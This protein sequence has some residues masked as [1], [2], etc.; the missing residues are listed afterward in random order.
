MAGQY[1]ES[2]SY[3][4]RSAGGG[5]LPARSGSP[6]LARW[7][8]L[9]GASYLA[10]VVAVVGASAA[11]LSVRPRLDSL[12]VALV[13]LL[14]SFV[15]ALLYGSRPAALAAILSFVAYNVL[16]LEPYYS[17]R[18]ARPHDL[19]TLL[20]FLAIATTTGQLVAR[21][22]TRAEIA[23]RER[24][25][26]QM[27]YELITGL[28]GDVDLP[29]TL[30][31]IVERVVSVFG[32]AGSRILLLDDDGSLVVRAAYGL[33]ERAS[34]IDR[35]EQAVAA[36]VVQHGALA[37]LGSRR[38]RLV[39][40]TGRS[41][42]G[43]DVIFL[44]IATPAQTIGV[45][46]VRGHSGDR[47]S[48]EDKRLLTGFT[49]RAALALDRARLTAESTRAAALAKSDE[50]KSA[51]LASV[52]HDLRTPL[53]VIKASATAMLDRSVAWP[54]A[55]RDDFLSAIDEETDRLT[56]MV[57]N[58]L[59][60]SRIE[61][62][63]LRPDKGW[64]DLG[65]LVGDVVRRAAPRAA[66]QGHALVVAPLPQLPSLCFDHVEIA[67]VLINLVE[68]ALT[69][70]PAGTRVVISAEE[71]PGA[72]EVA[73]RDDGPGID[74][75]DLPHVFETFYRSE[76]RRSAPGSG[77]GLATAK[78]LV[79]AHGGRIRAE[80]APG[81]GAAFAFTIPHPA[82]FEAADA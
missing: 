47:F 6:V 45:L 7:L 59:D 29:R 40:G 27:M 19:F 60:L 79:E 46:E 53:A 41:S 44:P 77:I 18:I 22:R 16:F 8:H 57:E 54:D 37:G 10:A 36:W 9:G 26:A 58:L 50:L 15:V 25:H 67:Q 11:M 56:R 13:Y 31:A 20:V 61:G 4:E 55:A 65:E 39:G 82:T 68:N 17:L 78:G 75:Q 76:R 73:V 49:S 69:H 5:Q 3:G 12:D 32:A 52:S 35:Q 43:E 2:M 21:V 1:G 70:T 74:A 28:I 24:R 66:E 23:E 38:V 34:H 51:L 30:H 48:D 80:S 72:V 42:R 63:V 14:L 62:G 33:D 64:H 81:A 71:V